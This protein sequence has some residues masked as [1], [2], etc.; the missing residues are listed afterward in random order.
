MNQEKKNYKDE[1]EAFNH[2]LNS[3]MTANPHI[4]FE[5]I[6]IY[7]GGSNVIAYGTKIEE[8]Y[9]WECCSNQVYEDLDGEPEWDKEKRNEEEEEYYQECLDYIANPRNMEYCINDIIQNNGDEMDIMLERASY[10]FKEF[11]MKLIDC[12]ESYNLSEKLLEHGVTPDM[13][14]K[15]MMGDLRI[16][17][18][19]I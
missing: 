3:L 4:K 18:K 11:L 14:E 13:L 19:A 9:L 5:S 2:A 16:E 8:D 7:Q 17:L 6:S 15:M 1:A 12:K 10:S